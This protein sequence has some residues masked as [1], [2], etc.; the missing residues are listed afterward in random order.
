MPFSRAALP[1]MV[2]LCVLALWWLASHLHWMSPLI[3]PGPA[4]V[5]AA[6]CELGSQDLPR[7]VLTSLRRL[8]VG[9]LI[10]SLAGIGLGAWMGSSLRA[11]RL[12]LPTFLGLAQVPTL[13][14]IPL[15]M[16]CLGIGEA[17]KLVVLVK[18]VI[19]PVCLHTLAGVR[20]AQP[21]LRE[22]ALVLRLS[23]WQRWRW[24]YTPAALPAILAG[25]RL[26]LSSGWASLLAV[27]LLASSEGLGYLMVWAR[28]MFM[29]DIV[30]VCI[31]CVGVLGL[32]MD[33]ALAHL[34]RRWLFWPSPELDALR[35]AAACAWQGA[36]LPLALLSFWVLGSRLGWAGPNLLPPPAQALATLW[37]GISNGTLPT[38]MA[39]SLARSATGLLLGGSCGVACGALLGLLPA[40]QRL[41]GGSLGALRQVAIFAWVPLLTAWFGLG[42]ASKVA[43]VALACF[44]PMLVAT[45]RGLA[46][47]SV[48]LEEAARA[49]R[50][51]RW[52]QL[53][54]LWLSAAA[55]SLFAG[56][57]V[58]LIYAWLGTLGAEYFMPS[59]G[60]IG[61]LMIGAEQLLRMDQ[62]L[63]AMLL[64][65]LA[66]AA[67]GK[68]GHTLEHAATAWRYS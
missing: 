51:G 4:Q 33:T 10:G 50:L 23:A 5:L 46:Q 35:P 14:W 36:V 17:L 57:R 37:S 45:Q 48:Q 21:R 43:F 65:S 8:A 55:P 19:V 40:A 25:V 64:I 28:Q 47:R 61:A 52:R 6:A 39:I 15:L 54:I 68:L 3:L 59:N 2:P 22:V 11:Q 29:L 53:R 20:D 58:A 38:A 31:A 27:E 34:E 60:G 7:Q 44:F 24:L 62:I 18:A 13:A 49:L 26:G 16:A 66:G 41:F 9:W 32:C 42:E 12:L 56:L 67:L 63:A 30:F 1:L